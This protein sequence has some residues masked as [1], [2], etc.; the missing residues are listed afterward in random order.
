MCDD[1]LSCCCFWKIKDSWFLISY[2]YPI[3]ILGND[4][5]GWP[6]GKSNEIESMFCGLSFIRGIS[7]TWLAWLSLWW[8]PMMTSSNGKFFRVTGHLCGE[9][10]GPR[11]IPHTKA[12][13][14]ELWCFFYL[15]LNKRLS[16]QWWGWWF[17]TLSRP[18]WRHR[19][20]QC[21]TSLLYNGNSYT[22]QTIYSYWNK[23]SL[24]AIEEI[25]YTCT[26]FWTV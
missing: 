19:N 20:A 9:F 5:N 1:Y 25:F 16:K 7:I 26:N 12:S 11:W 17:E 23:P 15:R 6:L 10:T 13:D 21:M 2:N 22:G 18:L 8:F 14:A 24:L 3:R 4:I